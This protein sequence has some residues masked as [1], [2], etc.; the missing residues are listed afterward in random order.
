MKKKQR[1]I[2]QTIKVQDLELFYF[3]KEKKTKNFC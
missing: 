2:I 3:K 1:T